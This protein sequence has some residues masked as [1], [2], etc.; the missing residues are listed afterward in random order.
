LIA[1]EH[2]VAFGA[3][4]NSS[5]MPP[6]SVMM[7]CAVILLIGGLAA[8]CGS[9]RRMWTEEDSWHHKVPPEERHARLL[10]PAHQVPPDRFTEVPTEAFPKAETLLTDT[11]I[12][13][14]NEGD[15]EQLGL[16]TDQF[17]AGAELY[18]VRAVYLN[19]YTGAFMVAQR[20][21]TLVV[22][23]GSLGRQAAPMA[24]TALVVALDR[25]PSI[26]YV[27]TTMGE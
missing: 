1:T 6:V 16:A 24:R 11:S 5:V 9:D 23:H 7:R 21:D 22:H 27:E 15:L 20:S 2:A 4:L 10:S 13:R 25:Q 18:L 17:A 26:V 8:A 3:P 12:V 14:L 19:P